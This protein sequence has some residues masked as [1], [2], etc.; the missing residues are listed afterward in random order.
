M[1]VLSRAARGI[2][3][4]VADRLHRAG[5]IFADQAFG[6]CRQVRLEPKRPRRA[7]GIVRASEVATDNVGAMMAG[8]GGV[9]LLMPE[10]N[11]VARTYEATP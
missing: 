3:I 6:Q 9:N 11:L 2:G 5:R 1:V 8:A 4:D 7:F 10:R